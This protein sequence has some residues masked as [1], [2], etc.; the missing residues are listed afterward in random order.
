MAAQIKPTGL[1][2]SYTGG[3]PLILIQ[4][5]ELNGKSIRDFLIYLKIPSEM[6]AMV[7]V[8]SI[9]QE[10]EYLVQDGDVIQL[11]PLIGGG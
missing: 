4:A 2:K 10:K 3:Q 6:V 1:L 5:S 9:L 7:L 8:N 11:V